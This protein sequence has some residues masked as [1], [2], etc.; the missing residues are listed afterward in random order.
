M[1]IIQL[2]PGSGDNFY[3]ENCLRDNFII[4]ALRQLGHDA[5]LVPLYLPPQLAETGRNPQSP[6]FFGGINVYLQQKFKLFR[7]TPRL[8]DKLF[9]STFLLDWAAKKVGMTSAKE[10][11]QTMIS[12]LD[13]EQGRQ[14]KELHRLVDW[15]EQNDHPQIICLSNALLIGLARLIKQ[16]LNTTV[17]CLLQD[18]DE[19]LDSLP[20]PY[21]SQAWDNLRQRTRD[22]DHFIAVS[23]FYAETMQKRLSLPDEKIHVNYT[24][25]DL[26][27][28]TTA[29]NPP[30]T[31]TIGY[32]SRIY[33]DKGL[34]LL[35]Q[36]FILLKKDP[37]LAHTR[38]RIAGGYT[39]GDKPFLNKVRKQLTTA[40]VIADVDF[41]ENFEL[42]H[43]QDFLRS[44]SVISVPARR[45]EACGRYVLEAL[46]CGTPFVQPR[47]GVF[48]ELQE[49]THGGLLYETAPDE[50]QSLT[51]TLKKLL[52]DQNLA[53]QLAQKGRQSVIQN[54]NINQSADRLEKLYE[55]FLPVK[56]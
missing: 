46:A 40:G 2:T 51:D 9:D 3:C 37:Q 12:M 10:L 25:L 13:G 34:D 16:R 4:K 19:F 48:P 41:L 50:L 44:L 35:A 5:V 24:G 15:L 27:G 7:K 56:S 53:A 26:Q 54:F 45:A 43:R 36:A 18:E 1:K 49:I 30:Q 17:V 55:T 52:L 42:N 6:V 8:L 47:R 31:P 21:S 28:F 11:G 39:A 29:D 33:P 38:L 20:E 32:L 14:V 22:V 23:N